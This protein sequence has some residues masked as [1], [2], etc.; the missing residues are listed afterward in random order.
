MSTTW[1]SSAWR[2]FCNQYAGDGTHFVPGDEKSFHLT[3]RIQKNARKMHVSFVV[4]AVIVIPASPLALR[5]GY[6][7]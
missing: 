6:G 3:R 7:G 2:N 5:L 1:P 4:F